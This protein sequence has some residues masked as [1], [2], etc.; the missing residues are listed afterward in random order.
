SPGDII[1]EIT[2][3]AD[4]GVR[5]VTLLGQNVNSYAYDDG[6]KDDGQPFVKLLSMV[7]AVE[8]IERV[9]F[10]TSHPKDISTE[11]IELF[12][13]EDKLARH[14]H[15]PVQSGSDKVLEMMGRGYTSG[16][17]LKKVERLKALYPEMSITTDIIVGFP[18]ERDEDFEQTLALIDKVRFDNIY[19]FK[20]SPR[21][22]TLAAGFDAQ[23]EDGIKSKRLL[24]LQER[25]VAITAEK[26]RELVGTTARVL[27]EGRSVKDSEELTGRSSINRVINFPGA[28]ALVGEIIDVS[29]TKALPNSLR[30]VHIE[31]SLN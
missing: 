5:E 27:V 19:S 24:L 10:V 9:R 23:V 21:P 6:S 30:G 17:Y 18:G 26:S 28:K 12:A 20:Y 15:L 2:A 22:E 14:I 8:K 13:K 1:E 25:Q 4:A 3:L 16:D 29:I 7:C 31:R 11:L